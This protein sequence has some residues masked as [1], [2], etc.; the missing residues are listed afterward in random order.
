MTPNPTLDALRQKTQR[1]HGVS[2]LG[3]SLTTLTSAY[4]LD[5]ACAA[6]V[7][8]LHIGQRGIS[9]TDTTSNH[10]PAIG[11]DALAQLTALAPCPT[12]AIRGL[13]PGQCADVLAAGCD[14]IAVVSAICGQPD[15]C[16]A[17]RALRT[18]LK[19]IQ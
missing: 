13:K 9:R 15:P 3:C 6:D 19:E 18:E 4:D 14:G 8:G 7:D 17:V 11:F 10:K 5:S 12:V 16:V 2:A 1:V